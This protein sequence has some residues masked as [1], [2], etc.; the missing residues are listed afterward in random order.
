[1]SFIFLI[2]CWD[3]ADITLMISR[4][5]L[6]HLRRLANNNHQTRV[7]GDLENLSRSL[8]SDP[9]GDLE[10]IFRSAPSFLFHPSGIPLY[11]EDWALPL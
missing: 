1:M 4:Q 6:H 9:R 7:A 8:V 11:G 5:S 3:A 2:L 10:A